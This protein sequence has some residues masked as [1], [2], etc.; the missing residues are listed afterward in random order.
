MG[1]KDEFEVLQVLK[2]SD[3]VYNLP[4]GPFRFLQGEGSDGR[5]KLT[6]VLL[7]PRHELWDIQVVYPK[8]VDACECGKLA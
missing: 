5:R 7:E 8:F 1:P 4:M 3:E 2:Q 6:K